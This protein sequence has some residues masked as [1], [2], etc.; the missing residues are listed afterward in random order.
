MEVPKPW[1]CREEVR[2]PAPP[3][4]LGFP[5]AP[6]LPHLHRGRYPE[7]VSNRPKVTQPVLVLPEIPAGTKPVRGWATKAIAGLGA[8]ESG[9]AQLEA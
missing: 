9:E 6:R 4:G 8:L 5:T 7:R 3:L 1:A 2:I